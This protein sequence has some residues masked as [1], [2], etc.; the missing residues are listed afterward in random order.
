MAKCSGTNCTLCRLSTLETPRRAFS[1]T[2]CVSVTFCF[3]SVPHGLT[4]L[5]RFGVSTVFL[6]LEAGNV[7]RSPTLWLGLSALNSSYLLPVFPSRLYLSE[8]TVEREIKSAGTQLT[9]LFRI[10]W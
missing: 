6:E 5:C 1:D 10:P 3:F 9:P 4:Q 2:V 7:I 8:V